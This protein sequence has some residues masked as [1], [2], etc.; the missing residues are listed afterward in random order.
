ML[1]C[2]FFIM[3]NIQAQKGNSQGS[4][5]A[6][7]RSTG[8]PISAQVEIELDDLS[9]GIG[10]Q[11]KNANSFTVLRL[12]NDLGTKG[13]G[14]L[15]L[16]SNKSFSSGPDEGDLYFFTSPNQPIVFAPGDQTTR[17]HIEANGFIGIGTTVPKVKLHIDGGSDA[18]LSNGS[19]FL[20]LGKETAQNLVIDQ[21]KIQARNNG[22]ADDLFL[23]TAG[24]KVA[25]GDIS[26]NE[27]LDVKGRMAVRGPESFGITMRGS[28]VDDIF[29]AIRNIDASN[30]YS[31]GFNFT[32]TAFE[33]Y[34]DDDLT[35]GSASYRWKEV[36]ALNATISTSDLR[37]KK[38]IETINYGLDVIEQLRPVTYEWKN[39]KEGKVRLGF[40]A[41]EMEKVIPEIVVKSDPTKNKSHLQKTQAKRNLE[42]AYGIRY[43]GLIPVLTKGIQE[44]HQENEALKARLA[45]M[46]AQ[47]EILMKK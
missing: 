20:L 25:I 44:L 34:D 40:I 26:P 43:D 39:E 4:S 35:L 10:I 22:L 12:H 47:I 31:H 21:N 30:T 24:G 8:I 6:E 28:N 27:D 13:G 45:K 9:D 29:G 18:S 7:G 32:D 37:L 2:C 5:E 36:F 17:L 46:E 42:D 3:S 19:G 38:N 1:A 33:P 16:N 11:S 15:L 41:Q 14:M 23:N